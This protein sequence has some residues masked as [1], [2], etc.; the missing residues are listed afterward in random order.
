[1]LARGAFATTYRVRDES[2][3][4]DFAL[5]E[6]LPTHLARR[7]GAAVR[8]SAD[9]HSEREFRQ[10]LSRFC[11]EARMMAR[12]DHSNIA[13]VRGLFEAYG[14]AFVLMDYLCGITVER[15]LNE[16]NRLP[17]QEELDRV[18]AP[19]ARSLE[20][21]HAK[22]VWH[23]GVTPESIILRTE[24]SAPFLIDF[25]RS[26]DSA[27]QSPEAL[28]APTDYSAPEQYTTVTARYGPWTDAYGLGATLYRAIAGCKPAA[29]TSRILDD[30]CT[31]ATR[32][33]KDRYRDAFLHAIDAA[34]RLRPQERPQ[35]LRELSK[36]LFG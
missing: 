9:P 7:E 19:I 11:D 27:A 32:I 36:K 14:T 26:F 30:T 23:L 25:S 31:P 35:S 10:G 18:F 22:G 6:F 15:W 12:L 5:K 21:V 16:L 1:V 24:D 17:L 33:G 13:G 28:V 2:L 29:A 20:L 34:M 4:K 8:F 3:G